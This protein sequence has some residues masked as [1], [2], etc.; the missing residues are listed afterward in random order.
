MSKRLFSKIK[1]GLFKPK[2]RTQT[3]KNSSAYL[4]TNNFYKKNSNNLLKN[5]NFESTASFRYQNK[6]G[7]V[8]TQELNIDYDFFENHTFFHSAVAK[9]NEAF[10]TIV[11]HY[12]YDG[13]LKEI[14]VFEDSL[15]GFEKHILDSFPKNVGYLNFSGSQSLLEGS[16]IE[17][18]DIEG[19]EILNISKNKS[20]KVILDPNL[21]SF[22]IQTFLFLPEIAND[23]QIIT[24]KKANLAENFS[25]VLSESASSENC[26][27]IFGI[28]SGSNYNAVSG[29]I[30]KGEFYHITATYDKEE[31]KNL[32]LILFD[33]SNIQTVISSSKNLEF[34]SLNYG[35]ANLTIG[36]GAECRIDNQIFTPKESFS[37]SM[38]DFKI[39]H[40]TFNVQEAILEKNKTQYNND[41]LKLYYKFNEPHGEYSGKNLVLDSS[42]N[43]LNSI[44][45]N[46]NS[47]LRS[48]GSIKSPVLSEDIAR[49]PIL[50]PDFSSVL[51]FNTELLN[52]G[53]IYDEVNP[54]LITKLVPR[55]YFLEG[56]AQDNFNSPLGRINK[57]F[58]KLTNVRSNT[59]AV[60]STQILTKFLLTWAK[61]FDELK[62][63]IDNFSLFS[64]VDYDRKNT[65]ADK[66]L[67]DLGKKYGIELPSLFSAGNEEQL[68][69]GNDI[70]E[71]ETNIIKSLLQ[72]QNL[73]WRNILTNAAYIT[74]KTGTKEAIKSIFKASGIEIE[75][76][77]KL[78]EYG[79]AKI[80][81]LGNSKES[82]K[83]IV[84][85]LSFS[86][87][88]DNENQSV[89]YFGYNSSSPHVKSSF[90][91]SSR[92]EIGSPLIKGSYVNKDNKNKIHG[93]SNNTSDGLLTSGS[94]TFQ[95]SYKF[96][97]NIR[98]N[99]QQSLV[100]FHTTGTVEPS[101]YESAFF[102]LVSNKS[103]ERIDLFF[104][105]DPTTTSVNQLHLTGLNIQDGD[106][107]NVSFGREC[108]EKSIAVDK[109]FY[110]LRAAKFSNGKRKNLFITSSYFS[111]NNAT[112]ISSI[113]NSYNTSGSF[114][115][116]GSQSLNPGTSAGKFLNNASNLTHKHTKFSGELAGIQF[117]S[118][119]NNLID[120]ER[121]GKDL[122]SAGSQNPLKSYNHNKLETGSFERLRLQT[123]PKQGT[124]GSNASGEI[125]LFDLSQ[126]NFHLE[127]SGFEQSKNLM[128]PH[129]L[130]REMLDYDF[131]LNTTNEKVRIRSFKNINRA[132]DYS[133]ASTTPIFEIQKSEE[134]FDDTRFSMDLSVMK[135]LN[136]NIMRIFSD[137]SFFDNALGKP[138]ILFSSQYKDLIAMRRMYFND[139]LEKLNLEKYRSL[140][141]WIDN[142]YTELVFSLIPRT[143][144]FLGINFIYESNV[145]E[146][147]RI[148]YMY[149]HLYCRDLPPPPVERR[150]DPPPFDVEI[151]EGDDT[152]AGQNPPEED[153]DTTE[154]RRE[155][156]NTVEDPDAPF[157][158]NSTPERHI[159][160][161][162]EKDVCVLL[163]QQM[164]DLINSYNSGLISEADYLK[165]YAAAQANFEKNCLQKPIPAEEIIGKNIDTT[166][167]PDTSSRAGDSSID[168][169]DEE[170]SYIAPKPE[171]KIPEENE[172]KDED[173][174]EKERHDDNRHVPDEEQQKEETK[175]DVI[176]EEL[177]RGDYDASNNSDSNDP[178]ETGDAIEIGRWDEV[179]EPNLDVNTPKLGI[180][181]GD[182]DQDDNGIG[183]SGNNGNNADSVSPFK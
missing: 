91:S 131:D 108:S 168:K 45:K 101:Q 41:N 26:E 109:S 149:D 19:S 50:F 93:E 123:F 16:Y 85:L 3:D 43:S 100:R 139:V 23:N 74:Q 177:A 33:N 163:K 17:V 150:D 88:V 143:T 80:R 142:A 145:L 47:S 160:P 174:P 157:D 181:L 161:R 126:N 68:F 39:F 97:Q 141:K 106:V 175:G 53:S 92:V 38:D 166:T 24:Q 132:K 146:R 183:S 59:N 15:T 95:G 76:L 130:I 1:P 2:F 78:R 158:D 51:T 5:T 113:A 34:G 112:K 13:S 77:F 60:S 137:F 37:G 64:H 121:Y 32:K 87:S 11:N 179:K 54:N 73:I 118:K 25:L 89:N 140:F 165:E 120:F 154:R 72:I 4:N 12:P 67:Q 84:Y 151:N 124:T 40:K 144:N 128:K 115:V 96:S 48:T 171:E 63:F 44:I 65:I 152:P 30:K 119:A 14:E 125:R 55:H 10:D 156:D 29:S 98:H 99:N 61:L 182:Y 28:T 180:G 173:I 79:G 105:D 102:N 135:G 117:W 66:F 7:I 9:T 90:L 94:F 71:N 133:F 164:I 116:I 49:S 22:S 86:G 129:Y 147:H 178:L 136:E 58:E 103:Q 21:N 138:N 36:T 104:V 56:N 107:W 167:E 134:V 169:K 159:P 27:L 114:I 176:E 170:T 162:D 111:E 172:P 46:Y 110:F 83:D 70:K 35:G 127:G 31:E 82:K 57:D 81:S 8:S 20:G 6:Q 153:I 18:K 62:L 122:L 148:K 52:S 69:Y 75:N 155:E 42:G